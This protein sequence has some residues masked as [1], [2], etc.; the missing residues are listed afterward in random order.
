MKLCLRHSEVLRLS[1]KV[2]LNVPL[3]PTGT[4]RCVASLHTQSVLLVPLGTLSSKKTTF[5]QQ[6][7]AVFFVAEQERLELSHRG[8]AGLRP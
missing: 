3:T 1:R 6:T 5:V 2:K 7:N 8:L 4:S